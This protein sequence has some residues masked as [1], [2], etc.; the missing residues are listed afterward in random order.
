MVHTYSFDCYLVL[1]KIFCH[2]AEKFSDVIYYAF[3]IILFSSMHFPFIAAI[4]LE[5]CL[6]NARR[7]KITKVPDIS[8]EFL[9]ERGLESTTRE[10]ASIRTPD[11]DI[12]KNH[13][14]SLNYEEESQKRTKRITELQQMMAL[15]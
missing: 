15:V 9:L 11:Q 2:I 8:Q 14:I 5:Q 4:D 1:K 7:E 10:K 12:F 13:Q 6:E 3:H